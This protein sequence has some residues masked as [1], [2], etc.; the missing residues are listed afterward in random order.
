[1]ALELAQDSTYVSDDYW[2]WWAWINGPDEELDRIA[3]VVYTLHHSFPNPVRTVTDWSTNFRLETEGW[4]VFRLY[5]TVVYDDDTEQVLHFDLKF[6]YPAE[7]KRPPPPTPAAPAPAQEASLASDATEVKWA[8][9]IFEGSGMKAVAFVGALQAADEAG[10]E[11]WVNVAGTSAGSIV[12]TL[13]AA[14]Y[15]PKQM[16]EIL[17]EADYRSFARIGLLGRFVNLITKRG[18][19]RRTPIRN[20]LSDLLRNSPLG[21][22]DPPFAA[23]AHSERAADLSPAVK[24]SPPGRDP[25]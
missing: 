23:F 1:M 25:L 9:G 10:I 11:K 4:G 14:G 20:W 19:S 5:A 15:E 8:D 24:F 13:L 12:A 17:L 2:K 3:R 18:L 16:R 6:A 7:A 21:D 22:A